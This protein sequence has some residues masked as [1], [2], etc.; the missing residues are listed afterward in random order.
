[1]KSILVYYNLFIVALLYWGKKGRW[2]TAD[3]LSALRLLEN[4]R[5]TLLG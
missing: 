1:M 5:R 3:A 2:M 4:Q